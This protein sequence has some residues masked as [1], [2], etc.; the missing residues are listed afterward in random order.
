MTV[1]QDAIAVLTL[2]VN[3]QPDEAAALIDAHDNPAELALWIASFGASH[4]R[5]TARALGFTTAELLE[6]AALFAA[7]Q[8]T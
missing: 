4:V 5:A 2:V 7:A 6:P 1:Q 8:V 3:D